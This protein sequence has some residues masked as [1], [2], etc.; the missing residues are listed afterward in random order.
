MTTMKARLGK[1]V[2]ECGPL[3]PRAGASNASNKLEL[4]ARGDRAR[5]AD[6]RK[7]PL[8]E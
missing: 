3:A 8:A 2:S 1:A 4:A 7:T 6:D 5:S